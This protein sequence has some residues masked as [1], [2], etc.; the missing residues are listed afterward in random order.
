MCCCSGRSVWPTAALPSV[1]TRKVSPGRWRNVTRTRWRPSSP[2][3]QRK[4]QKHLIP[5]FLLKHQN[6]GVYFL[7]YHFFTLQG[8]TNFSCFYRFFLIIHIIVSCSSSDRCHLLLADDP[9]LQCFHSEPPPLSLSPPLQCFLSSCSSSRRPVGWCPALGRS[10]ARRE[11]PSSS[12]RCIWSAGA[13]S[14]W[15][16]TS[17]ASPKKVQLFYLKLWPSGSHVTH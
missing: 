1:A 7:H 12:C 6:L 10:A 15:E 17:H 11:S 5:P 3:N 2:A 9:T 14:S 4:V 16:S 8:I 13:S